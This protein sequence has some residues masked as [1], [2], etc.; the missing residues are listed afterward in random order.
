MSDVS[1]STCL[2][3]R[4]VHRSRLL[5]PFFFR[6]LH[7]SDCQSGISA[8]HHYVQEGAAIRFTVGP[9]CVDE[10]V[11]LLVR[12][13]CSKKRQIGPTPKFAIVPIHFEHSEF[14]LP[15]CSAN[16]FGHCGTAAFW[17]KERDKATNHQCRI[18]DGNSN[19]DTR[20]AGIGLEDQI[21]VLNGDMGLTSRSRSKAIIRC[22][23]F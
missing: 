11:D 18:T 3:H 6:F 7:L 23:S 12:G 4:G 22:C 5:W 15:N 1:H 17:D 13:F 10:S 19:S 20:R 21:V 2:V 16:C 9:N 14:Q 8:R